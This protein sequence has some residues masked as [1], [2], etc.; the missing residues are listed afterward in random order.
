MKRYLRHDRIDG[1]EIRIDTKYFFCNLMTCT[2]Q[3]VR[4][5]SILQLCS[6]GGERFIVAP[7][8]ILL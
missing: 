5:P 3:G 6:R 4:Q 2:L 1:N 7:C 8:S